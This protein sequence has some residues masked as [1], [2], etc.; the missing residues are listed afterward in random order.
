MIDY[1]AINH[2]LFSVVIIF[3]TRPIYYVL[4]VKTLLTSE[5]TTY[6]PTIRVS[7]MLISFTYRLLYS[8]IY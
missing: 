7:L 1:L 5:T 3:Y 8:D 4:S 2:F 6:R